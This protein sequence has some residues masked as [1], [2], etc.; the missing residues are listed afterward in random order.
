MLPK[1]IILIRITQIQTGRGQ[2]AGGR[3]ALSGVEGEQGAGGKKYW[4]VYFL[5]LPYI[6]NMPV[7]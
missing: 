5:A 1:T 7:A 4:I 6:K 3:L 2:G